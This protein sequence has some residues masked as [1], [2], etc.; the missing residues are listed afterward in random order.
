[1]SVKEQDQIYCGRYYISA[2]KGLWSL[3]TGVEMINVAELI[4]K[5]LYLFHEKHIAY[6]CNRYDGFWIKVDPKYRDILRYKETA[7]DGFQVVPS[8]LFDHIQLTMYWLHNRL[9]YIMFGEGYFS[10]I[11]NQ[12]E[13]VHSVSMS[14]DGFVPVSLEDQAGICFS[15]GFTC[16]YLENGNCRKY[17][18]TKK[19]LLS[20][21]EKSG[22]I[23]TCV[24]KK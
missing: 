13:E 10:I 20:M 2:D 4:K 19:E 18:S 11:A 17:T 15:K 14:E 12:N 8:D 24:L 7:K 5:S 6:G 16:V 21:F 9:I 3:H 1:M 23:G 22:I